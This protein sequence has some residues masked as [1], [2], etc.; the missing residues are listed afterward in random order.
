MGFEGVSRSWL[1]GVG[2]EGLKGQRGQEKHLSSWSQG[3][4]N[5]KLQ[6]KKARSTR[7]RALKVQRT[8]RKIR[9]GTEWESK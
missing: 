5:R 9:D 7:E 1:E 6:G 8:L 4:G 3:F 2:R